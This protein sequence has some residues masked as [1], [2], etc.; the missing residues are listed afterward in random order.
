MTMC[1]KF[2]I[3][4]KLKLPK[5][6]WIN[7]MCVVLKSNKIHA[8]KVKNNGIIYYSFWKSFIQT[9]QMSINFLVM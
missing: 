5:K 4:K 8:K 7:S 3:N 2:K 6:I 1:V 9:L